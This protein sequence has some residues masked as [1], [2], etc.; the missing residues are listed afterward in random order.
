L[1]N[2]L[3]LLQLNNKVSDVKQRITVRIRLIICAFDVL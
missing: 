3:E 1:D 2:F